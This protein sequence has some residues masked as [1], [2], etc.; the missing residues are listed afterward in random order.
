MEQEQRNYLL[1]RRREKNLEGNADDWTKLLNGR[2]LGG[3][4]KGSAK[5]VSNAAM[6]QAMRLL[7]SIVA[8]NSH[9]NVRKNPKMSNVNSAQS[10][11]NSR[12]LRVRGKQNKDGSA[13]KS[14]FENWKAV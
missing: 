6:S 7:S 10:C 13:K 11:I 14:G 1:P 12:N 9:M 8:S 5:P 3:K 4:K 2:K